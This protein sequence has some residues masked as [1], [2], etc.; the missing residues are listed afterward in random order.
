MSN[1]GFRKVAK[2]GN[3]PDFGRVYYIENFI[4]NMLNF[5]HL[6]DNFRLII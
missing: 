2:E 6:R 1:A 5:S 3:A 4:A